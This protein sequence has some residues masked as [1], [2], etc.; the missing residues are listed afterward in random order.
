LWQ[1]LCFKTPTE[2]NRCGG[3]GELR[4]RNPVNITALIPLWTEKEF[5]VTRVLQCQRSVS[6]A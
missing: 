2:V 5:G 3:E 4:T 6:E 1:I